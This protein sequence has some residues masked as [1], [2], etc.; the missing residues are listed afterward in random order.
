MRSAINRALF[1]LFKQK[2]EELELGD[3]DEHKRAYRKS[4]SRPNPELGPLA[5]ENRHT[6]K[7]TPRVSEMHRDLFNLCAEEF[8]SKRGALEAAIELLA[9]QCGKL[10]QDDGP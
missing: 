3:K 8:A 2:K 9:K 6:H 10:D 5:E 4:E 1:T 7:I